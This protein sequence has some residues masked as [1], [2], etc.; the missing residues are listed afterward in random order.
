MTVGARKVPKW[1]SELWHYL[2]RGDGE[3]CP[4]HSRCQVGLQCDYC[5]SGNKEY[6][7]LIHAFTD[8]DEITL[9]SHEL[10][11]FDLLGSAREGR[12]FKL[13]RKLARM[14][15]D[16]ALVQCPPVPA[17]L[18]SLADDNRPI[19]I[20][21]LPLKAHHGA[22]WGLRDRWVIQLKNDDSPFRQRFTLFHEIFHILAHCR[23]TPV[24]R[25]IGVE[26][27]FFNEMLA[28]HFAS[29]ILTP[30]EWVGEKWAEVKDLDQMAEIFEVPK[31]VM[32]L[33]LR[34]IGLI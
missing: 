24:F 21:L 14:Y 33:K 34:T 2:S 8:E 32:W 7:K 22:I 26:E 3:V 11:R 18:I 1:E 16:K 19:E 5:L 12:I 4:L 23:A 20:H 30:A 29:T 15:F 25:K 17:D 10:R 31:T 6:I 28:D 27:G 9:S 13:I